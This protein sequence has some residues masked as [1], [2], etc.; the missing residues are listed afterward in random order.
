MGDFKSRG[1]FPDEMSGPV[2]YTHLDVYKRQIYYNAATES[3]MEYKACI[4]FN[5]FI[6]YGWAALLKLMQGAYTAETVVY[7]VPGVAAV[8]VSGFAGLYFFKKFNKRV[9]S[10]LVYA[11]LIIMGFYQLCKGMGPVSYTHLDVY[12]RQERWCLL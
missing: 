5:F 8:L 3:P 11:M 1:G 10:I 12:K 4:E 9:V 7:L 6:M 2:S